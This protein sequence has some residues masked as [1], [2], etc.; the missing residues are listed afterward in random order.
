MTVVAE[1]VETADERELLTELGYG[2]M[3]GYYFSA[4]RPVEEITS[5]LPAPEPA[6]SVDDT[7]RVTCGKRYEHTRRCPSSKRLDAQRPP[8]GAGAGVG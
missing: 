6:F 8:Q 2:L 7:G 3:Q 5:L 1:G 4:P